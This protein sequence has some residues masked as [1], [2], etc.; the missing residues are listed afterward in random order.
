MKIHWVVKVLKKN[1]P[2]PYDENEH[3][4]DDDGFLSRIS[5]GQ[6]FRE[7]CCEK[8]V[9]RKALSEFKS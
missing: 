5:V 9:G 2:K 1:T 7:A 4:Q 8:Q 6:S 3:E